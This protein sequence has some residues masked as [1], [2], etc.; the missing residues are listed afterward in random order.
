MNIVH[1]DALVYCLD[2]IGRDLCVSDSKGML[3]ALSMYTHLWDVN[4]KLK[5]IILI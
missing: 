1:P 4:F 3:L 2:V 5:V